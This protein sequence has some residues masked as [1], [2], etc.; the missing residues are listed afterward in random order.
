MHKEPH[1]TKSQLRVIYNNFK[2]MFMNL[3]CCLFVLFSTQAPSMIIISISRV[4]VSGTTGLN[5]SLK[6]TKS[7]LPA[8][9]LVHKNQGY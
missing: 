4:P 5:P 9:K 2:N 3:V 6:K 7:Y 1:K 8:Q